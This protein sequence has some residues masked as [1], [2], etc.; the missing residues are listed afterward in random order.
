M[1]SVIHYCYSLYSSEWFSR[2]FIAYCT[3]LILALGMIGIEEFVSGGLEA[4]FLSTSRFDA[5]E[6][7]VVKY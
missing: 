4:T 1:Q 2:S 5:D 6:F 7:M 3:R